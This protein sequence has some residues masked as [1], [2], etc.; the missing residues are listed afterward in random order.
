[1]IVVGTQTVIAGGPAV[2]ISGTTY[3]I[4]TQGGVVIVDDYTSTLPVY[5]PGS[6][7]TL[8]VGSSIY[9][10]NSESG[11]VIGS[12]TLTEGGV[13]TASGET[14]SLA[15]GGSSVVMISGS[16]TKT[17]SVGAA[18]ASIGGFAT[19]LPSYVAASHASYQLFP[20]IW[21]MGIV[22]F[23]LGLVPY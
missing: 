5:S 16:S 4:P 7:P 20:S 22:G 10:A 21:V 1:M 12:Q 23:C 6:L 8:V 13:I 15:P 11:F 14:L 18:I 2:I 19:P 3:R 17:E 9:T